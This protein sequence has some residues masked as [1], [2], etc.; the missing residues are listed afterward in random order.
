LKAL[1]LKRLIIIRLTLNAIL[2][3][4]GLTIKN[5]M[6]KLIKLKLLCYMLVMLISSVGFVGKKHKPVPGTEIRIVST[7]PAN[8]VLVGMP[9]NPLLRIA[10]YVPTGSPEVTYTGIQSRLNKT[11]VQDIQ[12]LDVYFTGQEP[13]F[14]PVN[15]I[16]SV[17]PSATDFKIPV[18]LRLQPGWHYLWVSATLKATAAGKGKVELH[19]TRLF[20]G[21]NKAHRVTEAKSAYAKRIGVGIRRGGDDQV[22]TCRIPGIATTDK[23][24]LI[25]VYDIRYAHPRDLP[26]NI[27]VGMS[28]STN[29]GKTWEPM[30]NIMDMGVPHENNGVGD[31]A[32]LFD[33]VTKKIWIAALW[34]KGNRS[35]AGSKPGL[36][37]DETGQLVL[38]SSAGDGKTWSEPIS[39]TS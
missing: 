5:K 31:P 30:K 38:V 3:S 11:A 34:S 39:V 13:L 37:P 12:K 33:P 14:A 2:A 9:A 21:Q 36:T 19:C 22:N 26:A 6:K 7:A 18:Q 32:I 20:D 10:I 15:A 28:R 4:E 24:T 8:P 16:A 29:G 25:A 17:I 23:G 27:D 35:I 1:L